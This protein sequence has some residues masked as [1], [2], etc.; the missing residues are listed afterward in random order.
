MN[1][2]PRWSFLSF[3]HGKRQKSR[4][5]PKLPSGNKGSSR[6]IDSE[7]FIMKIR[8]YMD[9]LEN[10]R[11]LLAQ[12]KEIHSLSANTIRTI[13]DRGPF[14][15]ETRDLI[16]EEN[17]STEGST[18]FVNASEITRFG[19]NQCKAK[20]REETSCLTDLSPTQSQ[21]QPIEAETVAN[22]LVSRPQS[23]LACLGQLIIADL[24]KRTLLFNDEFAACSNGN[25]DPFDNHLRPSNA[26]TFKVPVIACRKNSS[27]IPEGYLA[28]LRHERFANKQIVTDEVKIAM[29]G[30]LIWMQNHFKNL[31]DNHAT[32]G[33]AICLGNYAATGC[34][35]DDNFLLDSTS[36]RCSQ[37]FVTNL[38]NSR[39]FASKYAGKIADVNRSAQLSLFYETTAQSH[40]VDEV[41]FCQWESSQKS[42]YDRTAFVYSGNC[43]GTLRPPSPLEPLQETANNRS[44]GNDLKPPRDVFRLNYGKHTAVGSHLTVFQRGGVSQR[45]RMI[46]VK[47]IMLRIPRTPLKLNA[48]NRFATLKHT[49]KSITSFLS[50]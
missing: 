18:P 27:G 39:S 13:P 29:E 43:Q 15:I 30:M 7:D 49:K 22:E 50:Q 41:C 34:E 2:Q 48:R 9:G 31:I 44:A 23:R 46:W 24:C 25:E 8:F 45:C 21:P 19:T 36:A 17:G 14:K 6:F 35:K 16:L 26:M 20:V 11:R 5:A 33:I 42:E 38:Q 28:S 1:F 47:P 12:T 10:M 3:P 40:L 37:A 4:F 32:S